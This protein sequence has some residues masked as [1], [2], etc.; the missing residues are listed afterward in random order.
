MTNPNLEIRVNGIIHN[1]KVLLRESKRHT[2][3]RLA[4]TC[5]NALSIGW[6]G[7][8]TSPGGGRFPRSANHP[9]LTG[10]VPHPVLVVGG[11]TLGTHHHPD[12]AGSTLGTCP[13]SR[14][15]WGDP[16]V[17]PPSRPGTGYPAPIPG[18]GYPHSQTCDG[19][20]PTKTW[21]GVSPSTQTLDR[22]PTPPPPR[23]GGQSENITIRHP[24]DA[25]GNKN[26]LNRT[27]AMETDLKLLS[28]KQMF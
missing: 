26:K 6:G 17:P 18:I 12:L 8:P 22:V 23:N 10:G 16:E 3:R 5:Y 27:I 21:D 4:S 2:A 7:T 11:G 25:D 9:D 15:G 1:K 24:L 19:V 28:W 20:P 14:P 13:P